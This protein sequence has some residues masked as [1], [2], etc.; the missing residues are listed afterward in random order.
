MNTKGEEHAALRLS[1]AGQLRRRH[2]DPLAGHHMQAAA[3]HTY[4]P[5]GGLILPQRWHGSTR[6]PEPRQFGQR[7]SGAP[8]KH[9]QTHQGHSPQAEQPQTNQH[10]SAV[11]INQGNLATQ[12]ASDAR[13]TCA[14][15][16]V[17]SIVNRSYLNYLKYKFR[18]K[19]CDIAKE[20]LFSQ[21]VSSLITRGP[22]RSPATG[23]RWL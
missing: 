13:A 23:A 2:R 18:S 12:T 10:Y 1:C 22:P 5:S 8:M 6:C 4:G 21:T 11:T 16:D 19:L 3:L 7:S 20:S 9:T 15:I 14:N 17:Q